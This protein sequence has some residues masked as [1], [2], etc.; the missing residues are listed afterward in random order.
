MPGIMENEI[1][2]PGTDVKLPAWA[3]IAG[4]AGVI[5]VMIFSR[6]SS[7]AQ[8]DFNEEGYVTRE[9]DGG[10]MALLQELFAMLQGLELPGVDYLNVPSPGSPVPGPTSPGSDY[11]GVDYVQVINEPYEPG[12]YVLGSPAYELGLIG[13]GMVFGPGYEP[14]QTSQSQQ[15]QSAAQYAVDSAQANANFAAQGSPY[16]EYVEWAQQSSDWA[17]QNAG[18]SGSSSAASGSAGSASNASGNWDWGQYET[19]VNTEGAAAGSA[20][21]GVWGL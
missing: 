8:G 14:Y 3:I 6:G 20:A 19:G 13:A 11:D 15:N 18:S 16:D 5:A 21:S 4:V 9:G 12:G 2:I 17:Q 10:L 7:Q 1:E